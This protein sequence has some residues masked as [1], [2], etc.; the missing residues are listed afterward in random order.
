MNTALILTALA[1]DNIKFILLFLCICFQ[2]F[3]THQNIIL[4]C[5]RY[6]LIRSTFHQIKLYLIMLYCFVMSYNSIQQ[7][8]YQL[9]F[10]C[11][12]FYLN[13]HL[14]NLLLSLCI[15]SINSLFPIFYYSFFIILK[16]LA[17][18]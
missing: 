4:F 6:M 12:R 11:C 16:E 14:Y 18:K 5:L 9:L 2:T 3:Y 7:K 10:L 1:T 13:V 17:I 8:H 15:F